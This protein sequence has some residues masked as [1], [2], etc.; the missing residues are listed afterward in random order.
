V[1]ACR[2]SDAEK[3]SCDGLQ[4]AEEAG[5][6]AAAR[7]RGGAEGE[8]LGEWDERFA[9]GVA[10]WAPGVEVLIAAWALVRCV[11]AGLLK[12]PAGVAT[13]RTA[14]LEDPRPGI[15]TNLCHECEYTIA[16]AGFKRETQTVLR[17]MEGMAGKAAGARCRC[18]IVRDG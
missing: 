13:A 2:R 11:L 14:A 16:M 18:R 4:R 7:K 8:G 17:M 15:G 5:E 10:E 1:S 9:L 6:Q 3:G 12:L